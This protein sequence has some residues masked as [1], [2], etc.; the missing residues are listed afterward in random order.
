VTAIAE[1]IAS[2][3]NPWA[4]CIEQYGRA[5]NSFW[6]EVLGIEP[7]RW[8]E[9]AN[10]AISHGHTRIAIR[11]GHGVGKT[12]WLACLV[13]WFTCTRLP[14]KVGMTAPSSP[15]LHDALLGELRAVYR[16]L[17]VAWALL[18]DV[19]SDRI[20]LKSQPDNCFVTARTSRADNPESLQGLHSENLLLVIDE[21]SGVPEAVFEAAVGSMST[22]RAITVMTGNPTRATGMFWRAFNME[23]DR[24]WLRRVSCEESPRVDRAFIDEVLSRWGAES[25]Q[26]RVRVL[27]EFP[28]AEDD[29]LIPAGLVEGA[30]G[31]VE[32]PVIGAVEI[33][34]VDVARF[35]QDQSCLVKRRG[36]RVTE[37]PRR[38]QGIDT[39]QLAGTI[40]SEFEVL[41][42]QNR[43][44]LIAIDVIGIG[45]GVVD[46]LLEQN[47]PVLGVNVGEAPPTK[48]RFVRLRDQLW[49][50]MREW[51]ES[52][53]VSLPY[54]DRL[55]ADL[56]A[57]RVTFLSDGRMQ[58][59]SKQQL[60]ARGFASPDSGD[61]LGNTFVPS[62]MAL[63]L[64]VGNLL[65][66]RVPV[67]G[68]MRGME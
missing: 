14:F 61:A 56:C 36:N 43:P 21:A 59:E 4:L 3:G 48:G 29:T 42:V 16:S 33:W 39:M 32:L 68:P 62:G 1:A 58:V 9:E 18:F 19:Q 24:W 28:T 5:L 60:R 47:L 51:L 23:P 44:Q 54:D 27:G 2:S 35:G 30:M 63:Q 6:R 64:G 22:P 26:Y 40:K 38:W 7:D 50:S 49:L 17:P 37:P 55:R 11:S 34:G 57:P 8:Q 10:R 46:R 67:R 20:E 15:Q 66:T 12:L 13:V 31:R 65:N 52:L 41:P 45:A 53:A 25:N